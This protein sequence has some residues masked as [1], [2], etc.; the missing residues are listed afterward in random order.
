[1][2][3]HRRLRMINIAGISGRGGGMREY[4]RGSTTAI[5]PRTTSRGITASPLGRRWTIG[6]RR[7]QDGRMKRRAAAG[8]PLPWHTCQKA[9]VQRDGGLRSLTGCRVWET[10]GPPSDVA[11]RSADISGGWHI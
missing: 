5:G 6:R 10:T 2:G 8:S 7:G 1:M 3:P 11:G 9:D 4:D